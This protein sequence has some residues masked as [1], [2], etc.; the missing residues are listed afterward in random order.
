[1][2]IKS[3]ITQLEGFMLMEQKKAV[4]RLFHGIRHR[5]F[6]YHFH[7]HFISGGKII[8]RFP[9]AA[10]GALLAPGRPQ[11]YWL[12]VLIYPGYAQEFP[13]GPK[14]LSRNSHRG[15]VPL[16]VM[17]KALGSDGIRKGLLGVRLSEFT[18]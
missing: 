14:A 9:P 11:T 17:V 8:Y 3:E 12:G 7:R 2:D 4:S 6:P 1:M 18:S 13:K 15:P 5:D 16:C 10:A